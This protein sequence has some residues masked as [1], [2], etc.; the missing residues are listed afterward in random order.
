MPIVSTRPAM[1]GSVIAAS[2]YAMNPSRIVR[3][4]TIEKNALI[5]ASL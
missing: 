1:P 5:P 3:F 2:R 4:S